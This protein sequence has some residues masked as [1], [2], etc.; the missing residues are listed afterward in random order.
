MHC[1]C[2]VSHNDCAHRIIPFLCR[3]TPRNNTLESMNVNPCQTPLTTKT[4]GLFRGLM[5]PRAHRYPPRSM[6]PR[7]TASDI[8]LKSRESRGSFAE[9]GVK[10]KDL[11]EVRR[12]RK[13]Y[14]SMGE[15]R[16]RNTRYK[17][18]I[19]WRIIV[20]KA[21]GLRI[22]GRKVVDKNAAKC[23]CERK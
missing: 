10:A 8:E 12:K 23:L 18:D 19:I 13:I 9:K 21:R 17:R 5:I 22:K 15:K 6:L 4:F 1:Y 2:R 11:T 7:T 3:R 20:I 16:T 14:G